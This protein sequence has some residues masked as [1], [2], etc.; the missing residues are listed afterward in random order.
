MLWQGLY[1]PVIK[2][3]RGD[4]TFTGDGNCEPVWGNHFQDFK[5]SRMG[6]GKGSVVGQI[7]PVRHKWLTLTGTFRYANQLSQRIFSGWARGNSA[8]GLSETRPEDI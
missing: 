6:H 2:A 1:L 4:R 3:E 8:R 7:N 5:P